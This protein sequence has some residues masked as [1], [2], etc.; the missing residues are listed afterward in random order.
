[1]IL[2]GIVVGEIIL[3]GRPWLGWAVGI[4][5]LALVVLLWSY[6]QATYAAWVR[7]IAAALKAVGLVLLAV[8]LVE[9]LF[10]GTRPRPGSNLFL[11]VA[12]NSKSLQLSDRDSR[13]SRGAAMKHRLEEKSPWLTR[14]AQDFDVRRYAF[15]AALRPLKDFS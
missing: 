1:M 4:S 9:P 11:V 2:A 5:V 8:L 10:S 12:D 15:D 13:Q 3:G 6:F 7:G 14:L